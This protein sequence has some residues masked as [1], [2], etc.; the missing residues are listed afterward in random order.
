MICYS[1]SRLGRRIKQ[2]LLL[3]CGW[4][5]TRRRISSTVVSMF[6]RKPWRWSKIECCYL[7]SRKS[8]ESDVPSE[9]NQLGEFGDEMPSLQAPPGYGAASTFQL[10]L[11]K[12]WLAAVRLVRFRALQECWTSMTPWDRF[13]WHNLNLWSAIHIHICRRVT[14]Y[15]WGGWLAVCCCSWYE[16]PGTKS[17]W[18]HPLEGQ[19]ATRICAA[20]VILDDLGS[21]DLNGTYIILSGFAD[22]MQSP[23]SI[24]KVDEMREEFTRMEKSA[25]LK[26][27]SQTFLV[28]QLWKG[29]GK[30]ELWRE[31][32]INRF[33]G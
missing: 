7:G 21:W 20:D 33:Q 23:S 11:E 18:V 4:L 13:W 14:T 30:Q 8:K 9:V 27:V 26:F 28:R 6:L 32:S 29:E 3:C 19:C 5:W 24:Q 31:H 2:A 16:W 12:E 22:P 15:I 17:G 10:Y 1:S 25:V